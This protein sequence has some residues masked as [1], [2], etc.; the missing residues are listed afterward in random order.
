MSKDLPPAAWLPN[1]AV[2][3][4][5]IWEHDT[6]ETGVVTISAA[7]DWASRGENYLLSN[8]EF[9]PGT[10]I[11]AAFEGRHLPLLGFAVPA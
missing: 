4:T 7:R 6:L 8:P 9:E 5:I 2:P 10:R 1:A 3:V 11:I